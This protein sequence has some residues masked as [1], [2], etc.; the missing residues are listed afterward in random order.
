[1]GI[2]F[3]AHLMG[4]CPL[5]SDRNTGVADLNH[6]VHGHPTLHIADASVIPANLGHNPALT[7]TA[8]AERAF[9][10]WPPA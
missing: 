6:R 8:M 9:S 3:T 2:P 4:G 1:M 5:G 10:H 7:I